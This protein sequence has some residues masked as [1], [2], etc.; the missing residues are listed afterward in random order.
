MPIVEIPPAYRGPTRGEERVSVAGRTVR[1]CLD[2]VERRFP[3][4]APQVFDEGGRVHRFV[5]LFL[6]G[7]PV[8][9]AAI[10]MP[11][12]EQDSVSVLAAIA[13]G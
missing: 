3:G 9:P 6:N 2:A 12:K 1:E 10:D 5:K 13:G 11:V 8:A 7:E 4:F